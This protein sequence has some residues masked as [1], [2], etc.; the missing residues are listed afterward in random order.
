MSVKVTRK[1]VKSLRVETAT[2]GTN[3]VTV[4]HFLWMA[5]ELREAVKAGMDPHTTEVKIHTG[6]HGPG[7]GG[8]GDA[9]G[10]RMTAEATITEPDEHDHTHPLEDDCHP[11][12]AAWEGQ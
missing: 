4:S 8:L 11:T 9:H 7:G 6:G 1:R 3:H 10:V 5:D 12:C 2:G